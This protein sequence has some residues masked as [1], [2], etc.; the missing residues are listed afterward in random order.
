LDTPGYEVRD[1]SP[2]AFQ[3]RL[4]QALVE[5]D[6]MQ[7]PLSRADVTSPAENPLG[8]ISGELENFMYHDTSTGNLE[9]QV[10]AI[11]KN[12]MQH[13]LALS[14]MNNQFRLLQT[15]ISEKL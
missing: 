11:T 14:I 8:K 4:K 15:A 13:N 6:T 9:S 1:L 7:T 12:Q 3:A 5:R 2:A 10:A